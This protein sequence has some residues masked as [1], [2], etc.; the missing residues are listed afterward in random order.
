MSL[1]EDSVAN[2]RRLYAKDFEL[3][4]APEVIADA[5][6]EFMH[7]CDGTR[8]VS[9]ARCLDAAMKQHQKEVRE[10]ANS[11]PLPAAK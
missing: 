5:L 10:E 6:V 9:W 8:G 1:I 3:Y 4:P 2:V 7:F 11:K